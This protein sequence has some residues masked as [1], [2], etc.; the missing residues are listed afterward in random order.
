[1][2][3]SRSFHSVGR[4]L[5]TLTSIL[6]TLT[7]GT[8][9]GAPPAADV[10]SVIVSYADLDLSN[11]AGA[12]TL[13]ER[14]KAAA[15]K[16]CAPLATKELSRIGLWRDCYEQAVSNAVATIDRPTLTAAHRA[17]RSATG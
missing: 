2:N 15:R 11:P 16:V 10:P 4:W 7:V 1:M 5:A 12:D 8:A 14:I 13:Y 9:L 17:A 6:C 3:T